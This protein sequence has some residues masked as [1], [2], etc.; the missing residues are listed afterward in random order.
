MDIDLI[1]II[2]LSGL[3]ASTVAGFTAT[4]VRMWASNERAK[5]EMTVKMLLD[6]TNKLDHATDRCVMLALELTE[7]EIEK[8]WNG[9]IVKMDSISEKK[10]LAL[11][12]VFGVKKLN[13]IDG[14]V[15]LNEH[16]SSWIEFHWKTYLNRLEFMLSAWQEDLIDE[17]I[18]K[19][20][21]GTFLSY[22]KAN[23][24][25]LLNET[26]KLYF[27]ITK[28]FLTEEIYTKGLGKPKKI[29]PLRILS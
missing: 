8:I 23:L 5:A 11:E 19:A 21:L 13:L 6:W 2:G 22:K 20:Q 25:R 15:I 12:E 10:R 3:S 28:H 29:W 14:A 24:N 16:N 27:P 26:T 7:D 18:M 4:I 1:A 17:A 9:D